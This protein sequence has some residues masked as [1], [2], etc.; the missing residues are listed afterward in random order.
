MALHFLRPE[1]LL[2]FIPT[3]FIWGFI[4]K[5]YKQR[6]VWTDSVDEHLLPFV[7]QKKPSKRQ[8]GVWGLGILWALSILI[9]AGP[10]WEKSEVPLYQSPFSRVI[11]FDL[12]TQMLSED[13]KP[14]RLM[15]AQIKLREI[16][17]RS[18]N[19]QTALVV[20]SEKGFHVTPLTTDIETINHH[21]SALHP[22]I[23]PIQGDKPSTGLLKAY[24]LLKQSQ[25]REGQVIL[26][27]ATQNA[28]EAIEVA[29][30]IYQQG[31]SV[32]VLGIGTP[33][34]A[35]EKDIHGKYLYDTNQQI[36]FSKL[37]PNRLAELAKAGGG[38]AALYRADN[39]DIET[40]LKVSNIT[41]DTL[42][43]ED[44]LTV[45][46]DHGRYLLVLLLPLVV[47]SFRRGWLLSTV[48]VVIL[49]MDSRPVMAMTW[50]ELWSD[51]NS[52]ASQYLDEGQ[53][54]EAAQLFTEPNWKAVAS[55]RAKDFE[56]ASKLWSEQNSAVAQYNR[57][58]ALAQQGKLQEALMAY[59]KALE[60]EPEHQD[61]LFNKN[62]IENYIKQNE[63]EKKSNNADCCNHQDE[64]TQDSQDNKS[65]SVE[66]SSQQNSQPDNEQASQD[67]PEDIDKNNAMDETQDSEGENDNAVDEL[68][69]NDKAV[70]EDSQQAAHLKEEGAQELDAVSEAWLRRIPDDPA[71]LLRAKLYLQHI[72]QD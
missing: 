3:F 45:W 46:E 57:G 8:W 50:G 34:G 66:D 26:M 33:Q 59:Q 67:L 14:N 7:L 17:S 69:S 47:L 48:L 4:L 56:T 6:A 9:L 54:E 22:N 20:Y 62:I 41:S 29:Q 12:S 24:N 15:V 63:P 43:T 42:K 35:P 18:Q 37:N 10:S 2:A 13:L 23:M 51:P 52:K 39:Q 65:S 11:V 36:K 19:M 68:A 21:V 58:N 44:K 64:N 30:T 72:R 71:G 53:A 40:I 38:R 28:L 25:A 31:F 32:S 27:T 5:R 1:W 49:S 16:L 60:L 70:E 61:A 55:Y